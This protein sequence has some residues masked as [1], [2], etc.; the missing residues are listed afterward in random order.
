VSARRARYS[1]ESKAFFFVKK[2]QKTFAPNVLGRRD[3]VLCVRVGFSPPSDLQHFRRPPFVA[4]PAA[5][6]AFTG[7]LNPTPRR[8]HAAAITP[9]SR[10][11]PRQRVAA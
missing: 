10:T 4:T 6:R 9:R 1:Q 5:A 8:E 7:G 3:V 2:K 11:S